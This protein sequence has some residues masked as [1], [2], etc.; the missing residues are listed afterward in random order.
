MVVLRLPPHEKAR[1]S[2]LVVRSPGFAVL[3]WT[4]CLQNGAGF[5]ALI[6]IKGA[7][8]TETQHGPWHMVSASKMEATR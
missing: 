2:W 1:P 3:H 8:R 5:R 4:P 7:N 6:G